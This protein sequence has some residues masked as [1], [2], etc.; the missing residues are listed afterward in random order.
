M[1]HASSFSLR[2]KNKQEFQ[3]EEYLYNIPKQ[4]EFICAVCIMGLL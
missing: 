3:V 4:C 1:T 2:T